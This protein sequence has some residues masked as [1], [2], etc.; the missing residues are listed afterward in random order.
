MGEMAAEICACVPVSSAYSKPMV[1]P[2]A[3]ASVRLR[4]ARREGSRDIGQSKIA[5][6]ADLERIVG[7]RKGQAGILARADEVAPISANPSASSGVWSLVNAVARTAICGRGNRIRVES[8]A[9][10]KT[11]IHR[12]R[13]R[14]STDQPVRRT[15]HGEGTGRAARRALP[16]QR[17]AKIRDRSASVR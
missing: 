8:V 6:A 3:V 14:G 12:W 10:K 9:C 5:G 7:V 11:V 15:R 17:H 4:N 13:I 2:L 1:P 16:D